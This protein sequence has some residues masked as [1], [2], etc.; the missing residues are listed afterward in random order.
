MGI[1]PIFGAAFGGVICGYVLGFLGLFV[2]VTK[3]HVKND[4]QGVV[5]T[6]KFVGL[7]FGRFIYGVV[8]T[9]AGLLCGYKSLVFSHMPII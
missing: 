4:H 2:C 5:K 8:L 7:A 6:S 9:F 3:Y 1:I